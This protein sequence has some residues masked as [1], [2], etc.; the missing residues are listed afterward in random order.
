M[1]AFLGFLKEGFFVVDTSLTGAALLIDALQANGLNNMYGVVGIPVTD[2]ARLAQL[3]GM[4][5]YGFRREDSAVDAAAGAGFITGKPG[6]ALTVSAPGFLNGLTALA[7]ATKNCFPLIMIS[8]SSDRHIIDLDRGDYEG[9]D[10]YNVAKPFCKAAYRVDRAED[11][12]LAVARAVRTAVSG[13]PGGVYLDLP[14]AT[15]TDTV[16]QKSDANIYKVVDPAPKQLPSDD[17]INRAVELLKDAKHPVILLGK[18]SAYAQS[19]DEIRELVNKTNIP[20]LPMSMA[21]GVVPDDSPAS[22]ASARSFTLG[23]ADVVLLIGARLNWMLSNGESPLFSEDAKFIQVDIDATEFDSNRKIDAPL[24][25]DIKSVMQKLNSAAINAGV[26]AP[27]DWINAIKTESEKNNTKFAKRISASEAKS[28]LGYYSAIEPIN[29]LMQKHPDTYLVSEG[30]NTLDIGRDLI[31]MQKPRHR[32]DTGT[33]GV[34]GVGMGYAIAAAIETGKPV[35]ALEGDSAFGFDGMEME[36]IC[37]YHLPVIVVIINNGGI[38]NGDVNVVPDQPGPTVLDHNAH[39]GDI[40][41]A[42]GG[43]SYR[44]NN[45]EEMKDALEKAYESGNPTIIDAQIPES[46]GKESGHIGNLNP[47]LDLS[48]LEAKENK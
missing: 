17:A 2:F 15:V 28:T 35:I 22:A 21:K 27:T 8:G 48:S 34:M 12:G 46:M 16:A 25:G 4:K 9:L 10:Q 14:A 36:T 19:E 45:Y 44:V 20:F 43:D 26:K 29:D 47:K 11:M 40:S 3:K 32:L 5:Y 1:K 24:Q 42:F 41:K 38:Y 37:R 39:Y 31:G 7:Q 33:W 30:A 13:R 6:V 23:Q 18:G